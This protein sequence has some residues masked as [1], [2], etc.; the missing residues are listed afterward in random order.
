MDQRPSLGKYY[1]LLE[2][3]SELYPM[4]ARPRS[5]KPGILNEWLGETP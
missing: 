2:A 1:N 4:E 5:G 3:G